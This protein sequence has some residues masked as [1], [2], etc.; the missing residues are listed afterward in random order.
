MDDNILDDY[1]ILATADVADLIYWDS[2]DLHGDANA[3][4]KHRAGEGFPREFFLGSMVGHIE[5][6]RM[7][8]DQLEQK[9]ESLSRASQYQTESQTQI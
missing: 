1:R 9:L 7:Y 8:L 2:I 3:L 4:R 6:I 5:H